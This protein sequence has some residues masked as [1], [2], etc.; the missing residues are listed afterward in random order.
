MI[1]KKYMKDERLS[2]METK[3]D[4]LSETVV[5]MA[6]MEERNISGPFNRSL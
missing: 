4:K 1:R 5:A 3:T 6:Q 2:Q